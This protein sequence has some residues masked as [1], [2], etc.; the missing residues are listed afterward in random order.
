VT[1]ERGVFRVAGTDL[2]RSFSEVVRAAYDP[3]GI[4]LDKLEPG[5]EMTS[6]F[7]PPNFTFPDGR[8]LCEVEVD[9]ET[10]KIEIMALTAVDDFGNQMNP[11][12]VEGQIHGSLA[13]G[14]GQGMMELCAFDPETGQLPRRPSG[15]ERGGK[16]RSART[17][18]P[19]AVLLNRPGHFSASPSK[20]AG[21]PLAICRGVEASA[22]RVGP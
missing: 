19:G 4:P 10:G 13:Q 9:P 11:M 6:Y 7:N 18:E 22:R 16:R 8:H 14:V 3:I 5:L 17:V 21:R 1:F 20:R 15:P 12:I 2:E